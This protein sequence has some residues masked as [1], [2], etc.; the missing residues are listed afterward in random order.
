MA[1]ENPSIIDL[2]TDAVQTQN[3]FVQT[4]SQKKYVGEGSKKEKK[5]R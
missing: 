1:S 4:K 3:R 2:R 5:G